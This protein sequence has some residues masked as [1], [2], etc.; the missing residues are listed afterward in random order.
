MQWSSSHQAGWYYYIHNIN[1]KY[2]YCWAWLIQIILFFIMVLLLVV[3]IHSWIYSLDLVLCTKTVAGSFMCI[4][5]TISTYMVLRIQPISNWKP[6]PETWEKLTCKNILVGRSLS[7]H[8]VVAS[9]FKSVKRKIVILSSTYWI[10]LN[11][12]LQISDISLLTW[13]NELKLFT[14]LSNQNSLE[15]L[16]KSLWFGRHFHSFPWQCLA[17]LFLSWCVFAFSLH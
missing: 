10:F 14:C 5:F 1:N 12:S 2:W 15:I 4:A 8:D 11:L 16:W 13:T 17:A 6:R 9:K 3:V 7:C